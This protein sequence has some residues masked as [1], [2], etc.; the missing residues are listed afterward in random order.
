MKNMEYSERLE[1]LDLPTLLYR[2]ERGDMIETWKHFNVHD[3]STL[4]TNFKPIHRRTRC[5][6]LKL[7]RNRANDGVRGTQ[8]NS[9]YFR[10]ASLW[11]SLPAA[12]VK[13]ENINTF[14]AGLDKEWTNRPQKFMIDQEN[15]SDS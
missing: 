15:K 12:V 10:T 5:H 7:T 13:A 9:F 6:D 4:S 11:N 1:K 2:R 14:K 8:A 3:Q